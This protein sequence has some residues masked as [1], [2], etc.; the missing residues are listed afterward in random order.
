MFKLMDKKIIAIL[1]KR[2]CLAGPML[3]FT[4]IHDYSPWLCHSVDKNIESTV[5]PN[6]SAPN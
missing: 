4:A 3:N 1:P 5:E 6:Q 2:F